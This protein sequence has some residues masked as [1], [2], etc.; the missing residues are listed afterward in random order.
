[1]A[2]Y[3]L[4]P[5]LVLTVLVQTAFFS[6][7]S[8]LGVKP[9]L[10][11]IAAAVWAVMRG[12][13]EGALWVILGGLLVDLFSGAPLGKGIIALTPV[14][15][16]AMAAQVVEVESGFLL[17]LGVVFLSAFFYEIVSRLILQAQMIWWH[18]VLWVAL[19]AALVNTVLTPPVYGA[20][21][22]LRTRSA[23]VKGITFT[24][25]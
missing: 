12:V 4:V 20:L 8:L 19:P 24:R 9:D 22:H 15:L 23:P 7:I 21:H 17:S 18:S 11:L 16:L 25:E 6:Q 1:M 3:I 13:K 2:P 14:L 10:V 5:I